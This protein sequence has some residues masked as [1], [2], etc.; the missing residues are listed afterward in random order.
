[1]PGSELD[2]KLREQEGRRLWPEFKR[3]LAEA[4]GAEIADD[5]LAA[6]ESNHLRD[7]F[8]AQLR[9][10]RGVRRVLETSN[11]D[12]VLPVLDAA[13]QRTVDLRAVL[14][15]P[16]DKYIGG[17]RVTTATLLRAPRRALAVLDGD[18]TSLG[19]RPIFP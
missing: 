14:L 2:R 19:G 8:V 9:S 17:L 15:H 11:F 6:D 7:I 10:G 3:A 16:R 13:R 5:R 4:V 1:M 18:I 12:E